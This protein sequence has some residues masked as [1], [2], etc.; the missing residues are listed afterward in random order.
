MAAP[1]SKRDEAR[2]LRL[3]GSQP[4]SSTDFASLLDEVRARV[5]DAA[6][7]DH[8]VRARLDGV[9]YEILAVDYREDKP[10]EQGSVVRAGEVAMYDYDRDVLVVAAVDLR[11]GSLLELFEREGAAPPITAA[12]LAIAVELVTQRGPFREA[13]ARHPE[14]V[15]AFP[16]PSYAFDANPRRARHRGCT[17]YASG[18]RG[19]SIAATVDLT[20]REL[21]PDTELPDVLRSDHQPAS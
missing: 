12:E 20:A 13:L 4:E 15:A 14:R 6:L 2:A 10:A 17:V 5:I 3:A 1:L 8:Q 19:E 7:A 21:V 11:S 18:P 16:T 9:R